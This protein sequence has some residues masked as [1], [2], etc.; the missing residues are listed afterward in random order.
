M[1]Q[2]PLD[3]RRHNGGD[4]CHFAL[5]RIPR[6]GSIFHNSL[7]IAFH[8][9]AKSLQGAGGGIGSFSWGMALQ[10]TTGENDLGCWVEIMN[11]VSTAK[12]RH[13][14]L[15]ADAKGVAYVILLDRNC[16]R[17]QCSV[18]RDGSCARAMKD[19]KGKPVPKFMVQKEKQ[20]Q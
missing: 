9:E 3:D 14:L 13:P 20:P 6:H 7:A 2:V 5:E 4:P 11:D 18:D 16:S 1:I 10:E 8:G 19:K 15:F 17:F 12:R